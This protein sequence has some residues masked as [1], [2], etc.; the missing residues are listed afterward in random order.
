VIR[1]FTYTPLAEL[2]LEWA[3]KATGAKSK[4]SAFEP[5]LLLA[6]EALLGQDLPAAIRE[7]GEQLRRLWAA[8][9]DASQTARDILQADKLPVTKGPGA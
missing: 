5:I 7:D 8:A 1:S 6:M 2:T 9:R 4:N 3:T